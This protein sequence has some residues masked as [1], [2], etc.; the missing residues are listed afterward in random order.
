[1][2]ICDG[3]KGATSVRQ[4]GR[5]TPITQ[6]LQPVWDRRRVAPFKRFAL[7][8]AN[9]SRLV[10][11]RRRA[12]GVN[13][14]LRGDTVLVDQA[15]K[16]VGPL[17]SVRPAERPKD[18]AGD[19]DSK[20]YAA[21]R[22]L[23]V[24]MLDELP[25]YPIG[26]SL[27]PDE[28]PVEAL[29]PG[30]PHGPLGERVRPRRSHGSPEGPGAGRPHHLVEGTDELGGPVPDEEPHRPALVFQCDREVT[31]VLGDPGSDRVSGHTSQEDPAA[32]EVDEEQHIEAAQRDRADV[33]EVAGE[34]IG[35]L[36]PQEL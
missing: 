32:L 3:L 9:A 12:L 26:M 14:E 24:V 22:S 5:V 34:G 19:W 27:T 30:C 17:G 6:E 18:R 23:I 21:V 7:G 36:G 35:G 10:P 33:K 15:T 29:G 4:V 16:P 1:M 13:A 20:V 11:R 8:A 28:Q 2:E 25:Q 31:S